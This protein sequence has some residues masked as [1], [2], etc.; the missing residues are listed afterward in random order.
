MIRFV[1]FFFI[2]ALLIV[3]CGKKETPQMKTAA[4]QQEMMTPDPAAFV[5]A[6]FLT[7]Q[8]AKRDA[9]RHDLD[10]LRAL[11]VID[12]AKISSVI[13]RRKGELMTLKKNLRNSTSLSTAQRDSLIAPLELESIELAGDLIAVAK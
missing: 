13:N 7:E 10:S 8:A 11:P 6:K 1:P 4:P 12:R 3:G 2:G 5:D 9:L